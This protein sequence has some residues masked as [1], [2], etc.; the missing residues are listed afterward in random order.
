MHSTQLDVAD[1]LG[2]EVES[3]PKFICCLWDNTIC[4]LQDNLTHSI[5]LQDNPGLHV[6]TLELQDNKT[7]LHDSNQS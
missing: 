5:D 1:G 2:T 7:G 3:L 6:T 4:D